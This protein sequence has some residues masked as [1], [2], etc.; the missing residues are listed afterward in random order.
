MEGSISD[1]IK[2]L[3]IYGWVNDMFDISTADFPL[4]IAFSDAPAPSASLSRFGRVIKD[5][6]NEGDMN[7]CLV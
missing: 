1:L 6:K 5:R 4:L 7:N 3:S 2:A